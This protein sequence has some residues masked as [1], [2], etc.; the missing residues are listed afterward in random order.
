MTPYR[1]FRVQ[2]RRLCRLSPSFL[3]V[4]FGGADLGSFADN[5]FD[6]RIKLVLPLPGCGVDHMP[7]GPDWYPGGA[8]C[9]TTSATRS[10]PTRCG[11]PARTT[12][13]STW[14]W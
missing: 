14:T 10:A 6:Q 13:R 1:I 5:G 3:R 8:R 4:T 9:R 7:T 11:P 2:V 12:R